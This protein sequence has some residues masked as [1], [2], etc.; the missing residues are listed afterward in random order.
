MAGT[1]EI[2]CPDCRRH[3]DVQRLEGDPEAAIKALIKCPDCVGGD[4]G[5]TTFLDANGNEVWPAP[6]HGGPPE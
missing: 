2:E 3:E 4:F 5:D 6:E 1:I